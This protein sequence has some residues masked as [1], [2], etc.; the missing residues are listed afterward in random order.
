MSKFF[1]KFPNVTYSVNGDGVYDMPVDI[2]VRMRVMVEKLD[3][4]F[5]YYDYAVREGQTP[6]VI[7]EQY[8]GDA[9]LHWLVLMTNNITDPFNDWIKH[10]DAFNKYIINKYGSL[11]NAKTTIHH[12]EKIYKTV[13]NFSGLETLK[14]IEVSQDDY[15]ALP[16]SI[17]SPEVYTVGNYT[18]DY[19]DAYRNAVSNYDWEFAENEKK[20]NIKLIRKEYLPRIKQEFDNI[21]NAANMQAMKKSNFLRTVS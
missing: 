9:E 6:E 3:S 14:I 5:N 2:T 17:G 1:D 20:R 8:Y 13:D 4:V 21:L 7:A 19:Y 15:N 18:V 10:Y 12:Y 11:A 16:A